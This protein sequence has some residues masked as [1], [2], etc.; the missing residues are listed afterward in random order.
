VPGCDAV[1]ITVTE[2][3]DVTV[4]DTNNVGKEGVSVYAFDGDAY[5]GY[6]AVTNIQGIA[7]F[8]LPLGSYR[9]RADSTPRIGDRWHPILER[10]RES[11]H[12]P[13]L[14]RC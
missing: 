10:D 11:L 13:G 4:H 2:P 9:F 1:E 12:P 6:S 8:T 7:S 14:H 5:T 3:I